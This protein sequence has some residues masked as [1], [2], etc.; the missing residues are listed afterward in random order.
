MSWFFGAGLLSAVLIVAGCSDDPD[1]KR[2]PRVDGGMSPRGNRD[3]GA[4]DDAG[5]SGGKDGGPPTSNDAGPGGAGGDN[6]VDDETEPDDPAP[7]GPGGEGA[8]GS[9]GS[10]D[11]GVDNPTP[12]DAG[13]DLGPGGTGS[14]QAGAAN[15]AGG[16]A[17]S[18]SGGGAGGDGPTGSA[19]TGGAPSIEPQVLVPYPHIMGLSSPSTLAV[20][21]EYVYWT[22]SWVGADPPMP[23]PNR[24]GNYLMRVPKDGG[25][26]SSL[27]DGIWVVDGVE[28][29]LALG[30]RFA[31]DATHFYLPTGRDV[32]SSLIFKI[33]KDG[34]SVE[35]L[36]Q[37]RLLDP[38]RELA[39]SGGMLYFEGLGGGIDGVPID[40]GEI[41]SVVDIDTTPPPEELGFFPSVW[42]LITDGTNL[43]YSGNDQGMFSVPVSGGQPVLISPHN[44]PGAAY[45]SLYS[46]PALADGF[47]YWQ[48]YG[49]I[50]SVP[51]G[52]GAL[53]TVVEPIG[54]E[55]GSSYPELVIDGD[56]LY[57][58]NGGLQKAAL[59][60]SSRTMVL[61]DGGVYNVNSIAIDESSVYMFAASGQSIIKVPK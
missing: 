53:T 22:S 1:S 2:A 43:Y 38:K 13:G 16:S 37:P 49:Y 28:R 52:G 7:S 40:G 4:V 47:L 19:G 54:S 59:D 61:R 55:A 3:G 42:G 32:Y 8:G 27:F 34:S 18:D 50:Y 45:S 14:G 48:H 26:P 30:A 35:E 51:V 41:F 15:S 9:S 36:A 17:G 31:M 39:L 29:Q 58:L 60:G 10:G 6:A 23:L 44:M 5:G 11:G 25:E 12:S 20:D 21:D 24:S 33:A 46:F 56:Y 57:Y